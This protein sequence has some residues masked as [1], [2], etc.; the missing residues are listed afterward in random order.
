MYAQTWQQRLKWTVYALLLLDF[1][2]YL[3]QDWES[4]AYTLGAHPAL[5]DRARA[6]VTSIDVAA[7][8]VLILCFELETYVLADDQWTGLTR[9]VVRGVRLMCYVA[10]LNTSFSGLTILNDYRNP[11]A[12]A[13]GT[14]L[15]DD[16]YSDWSFLRNRGYTDLDAQNCSTIGED[17]EYVAIGDA[18]VVTDRAG[19]HEGLILAWTDFVESIAWLLIVLANELVV[20]IEKRGG[21]L[22]VLERSK[23]M[24]YALIVGIAFY[25]GS[26]S[27]FLYLWDELLWVCGFFAIEMNILDWK[28]EPLKATVK[29][30][31][32]A[33]PTTNRG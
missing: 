15:C 25:W 30:A 32:E 8:L 26:K 1:V 21:L 17:R 11:G 19:L 14:D 9:W 28:S 29:V 12:L 24:L 7:W 6:Y 10:I 33:A 31:A 16:R 2:L 27:Q 5:L 22:V 3:Y 4:A 18:H 20:R 23:A 13:A